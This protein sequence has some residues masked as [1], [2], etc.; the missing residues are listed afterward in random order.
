[1]SGLVMW[2]VERGGCGCRCR[3]VDMGG[4]GCNRACSWADLSQVADASAGAGAQHAYPH[5]LPLPLQVQN[6]ILKVVL[7]TEDSNAIMV[8]PLPAPASL[9]PPPLATAGPPP[10]AKRE[11]GIAVISSLC[12]AAALLI[13]GKAGVYMSFAVRLLSS[14]TKAP[15]QKPMGCCA[16]GVGATDLRDEAGP[17][18]NSR[19]RA[20]PRLERV[21]T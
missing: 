4:R 12:A 14:T 3:G 2:L 11:V 16:C 21:W 9:S 1:M 19:C 10:W 5:T 6:G 13:L 7:P 20:Q 15:F 18:L 8:V 17:L